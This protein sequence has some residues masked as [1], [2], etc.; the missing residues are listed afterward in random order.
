MVQKR[1]RT[2]LNHFFTIGVVMENGSY[3][4]RF[5]WKRLRCNRIAR[6]L[7]SENGMQGAYR[8]YRNWFR[9]SSTERVISLEKSE[10]YLRLQKAVHHWSKGALPAL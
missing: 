4:A 6:I 9:Y 2:F 10:L 5:L 7:F 1:L 8:I 3:S